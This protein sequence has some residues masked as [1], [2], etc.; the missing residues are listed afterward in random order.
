MEEKTYIP[1]RWQ[2][3]LMITQQNTVDQ[4][5]LEVL[6]KEAWQ[7]SSTGSGFQDWLDQKGITQLITQQGLYMEYP[8]IWSH[9]QK[10]SQ[11][12]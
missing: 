2:G 6:H 1:T 5:F 4:L 8:R 9:H 7:N 12:A 3:P 10:T 11:K